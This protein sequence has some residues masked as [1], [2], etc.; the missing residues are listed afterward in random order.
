MEQLQ[1]EHNKR[2]FIT[3][4]NNKKRI[5]RPTMTNYQTKGGVS[6]WRREQRDI[7]K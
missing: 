3:K 5:S 4:L 7:N 2:P 1:N 6:K